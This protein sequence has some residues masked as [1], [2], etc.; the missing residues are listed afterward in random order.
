MVSLGVTKR[1]GFKVFFG[2]SGILWPLLIRSMTTESHVLQGFFALHLISWP[3]IARHLFLDHE[4]KT[5]L[6]IAKEESIETSEILLSF[7]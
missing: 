1:S 7:P 2:S 6:L 4:S 5:S 3:G